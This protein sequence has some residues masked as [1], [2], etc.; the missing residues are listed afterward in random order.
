MTLAPIADNESMTEPAAVA[1]AVTRLSLPALPVV[2]VRDGGPPQHA[3]ASAAKARALRD[4]CLRF[5]PRAALPL[6]P[7]LD[8]LARTVLTRTGSPYVAEVERIAASLGVSGVWLLNAS[9]Q[10]GCTA[11]TCAQDGEPWLARTL[12]WPFKGLGRHIEFA[13]MRGPAGEFVSVTWPGYV[14]LL[15]G[16]APGRFAA[17]LNQAPMRRQTRHRWLRPFD[18]FASSVRASFCEGRLP[19]DQALRRAFE[20]CED[21]K[22]ARQFLETVPVAR[23]A[24]FILTGCAANEMCVIERTETESL[25]RDGAGSVANDWVPTRPGW[26]GRIGTRRFLK[27]SFAE[28]AAVSEAKREAIAAWN[29]A[30]EAPGFGWLRAPVLNP[31]TRIAV[32][33]NPRRGVIRAMGYDSTGGLLPEPVTRLSEL[34]LSPKPA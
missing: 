22:A 15:T 9:S 4:A 1:S 33:M 11:R 3:L 2:D 27:V 12:D 6:V 5:F 7:V 13:R 19:P 31:V 17:A 21:F 26:E 20:I 32:T 16:L 23:P 30:M 28:A 10:W 25:T 8:R 24:I 14:G 29:G 34:A 18:F